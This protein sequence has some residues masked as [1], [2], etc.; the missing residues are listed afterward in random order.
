MRPN[1]ALEYGIMVDW[2]E[3]ERQLIN[4]KILWV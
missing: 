4:A 1:K 3:L 2:I